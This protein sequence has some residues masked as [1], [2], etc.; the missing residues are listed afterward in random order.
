MIGF[1]R[2][3]LPERRLIPSSGLRGPVPMLF[4]IMLFIMTIVAAAGLGLMHTAT[5]M[6]Q[7]I[8]H[9][10]TLQIADGSTKSAEALALV[11]KVAGVTHA[12]AVPEA[13]LRQ[14]MKQWLGPTADSAELPV[15][16]IVDFDIAAGASSAAME[17]ALHSAIPS[18]RVQ[19]HSDTLKPMLNALNGLALIALTL[20]LLVALAT[21]AA[22][23]LAAR[24]ALNNQRD[25][26]DVMHGIG[27]TDEQIARPFLRQLVLD[28]LLGGAVGTASAGLVLVALVVIGG[29]SA[30]MAGSRPLGWL[31]AL[32]LAL[33][34][35]LAAGLATLVASRALL[36]ALR[37]HL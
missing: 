26:I 35:V 14:T 27:A 32:I 23:I 6:R 20:T 3:T 1:L 17:R 13:E 19:A 22:V 8:A 5:T 15:P 16:V 33:L 2:A 25:T 30:T 29:L 18:A 36:G 12:E 9:R 21:S 31:D 37:E 28:A 11:R 34:P 10:Y 24:S 4:A 7:G